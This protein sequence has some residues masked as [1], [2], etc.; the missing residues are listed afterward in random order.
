MNSFN[1]TEEFIQKILKPGV[2]I[3]QIPKEDLIK[4]KKSVNLCQGTAIGDKYVRPVG[5]DKSGLITFA[6]NK[7][8]RAYVDQVSAP[9]QRA[10]SGFEEFGMQSFE[11]PK[12]SGTRCTVGEEIREFAPIVHRPEERMPKKADEWVA[13]IASMTTKLSSTGQVESAI[14]DKAAEGPLSVLMTEV[15]L[16]T[17]TVAISKALEGK[18]GPDRSD[19]KYAESV[20]SA[21]ARATSQDKTEMLK[22]TYTLMSKVDV[23]YSDSTEGVSASASENFKVEWEG[24]RLDKKK[25]RV[26]IGRPVAM[27][28]KIKYIPKVVKVGKDSSNVLLDQFYSSFPPKLINYYGFLGHPTK[29]Q[30][31]FM[32]MRPYLS[33]YDVLDPKPA[34]RPWLEA[35][36][37]TYRDSTDEKS[38]IQVSVQKSSSGQLSESSSSSEIEGKELSSIRK[39]KVSLVDKLSLIRKDY[40]EKSRPT[41][42][43]MYY[44]TVTFD[45][46]FFSKYAIAL[47]RP[48]INKKFFFAPITAIKNV[49]NL[50]K[51]WCSFDLSICRSDMEL[52]E[53]ISK[54]IK[55]LTSCFMM[56]IY[57]PHQE[58]YKDLVYPLP[59]KGEYNELEPELVREEARSAIRTDGDKPKTT[60]Q[61]IP[62]DDEEEE[63]FTSNEEEEESE[64]E[65]EREEVEVLKEIEFTG[66]PGSI[67][68]GSRFRIAYDEIE[69][70]FDDEDVEKLQS[71]AYFEIYYD[72]ARHGIV[73]KVSSNRQDEPTHILAVVVPRRKKKVEEFDRVDEIV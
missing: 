53:T 63:N 25:Q 29:V 26:P 47:Y 56:G 65:V 20:Y 36:G 35:G 68:N 62:M 22:A 48:P 11:G 17:Y 19:E 28:T 54:Y 18:V 39:M 50:P 72:G 45:K 71:C 7:M 21:V 33:V 2:T 12:W 58:Q 10:Y 59:K 60:T 14:P 3:D 23:K 6:E 66:L 73:G 15:S 40:N 37:Y 70:E 52:A 61:L 38:G 55:L 4:M 27:S 44:G 41:V 31:T 64:S 43:A 9:K 69:E 57:H 13:S 24:G 34:H 5:A 16:L 51:K 49:E 42:K 30:Q 8:F 46:E 1:L 67:K 32:L